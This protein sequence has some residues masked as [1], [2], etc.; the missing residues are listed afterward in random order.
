[1]RQLLGANPNL[2]MEIKIDPAAPGKNSP[3]EHGMAGAI[4][5]QWLRLF[6]DF[7]DRFVIGSDQYYPEPAGTVQRW[8]PVVLL[9][10]VAVPT[11][12]LSR[13]D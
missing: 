12:Q 13:R 4:K 2:Y 7:S 1:M 5:P 11:I 3:L 6:Q 8:Q 10:F 9:L